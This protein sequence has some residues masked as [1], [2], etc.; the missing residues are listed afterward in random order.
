MY[1]DSDDRDVTKDEFINMMLT[2]EIDETAA[3]IAY[4]FVT[5]YGKKRM[6]YALFSD[7]MKL[8]FTIDEKNH[9]IN[10]GL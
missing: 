10:M 2:W 4:D 1:D 9:P 6:D 5:E 7:F 3:E 8:F